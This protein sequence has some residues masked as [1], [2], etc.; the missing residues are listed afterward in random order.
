MSLQI[1][2]KM[3]SYLRTNTYLA[4]MS[5]VSSEQILDPL[6]NTFNIS[7]DPK[8]ITLKTLLSVSF[9]II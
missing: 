3:I 1:W 4:Q 5:K 2:T 6:D 9:L 8:I 7:S